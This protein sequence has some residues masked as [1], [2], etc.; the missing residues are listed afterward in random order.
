MGHLREWVEACNVFWMGAVRL[1]TTLP[2]DPAKGWRAC[3]FRHLHQAPSLDDSTQEQAKKLE[4]GIVDE[5]IIRNLADAGTFRAN[6]LRDLVGPEWFESSY[7]RR[8]GPV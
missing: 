4:Q 6:R 7:Y 2:G 8:A 1:D 5:N 3:A